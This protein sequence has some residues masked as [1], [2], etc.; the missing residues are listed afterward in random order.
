MA[1]TRKLM[2]VTAWLLS[3]DRDFLVDIYYQIKRDRSRYVVIKDFRGTEI[4]DPS[5]IREG[6]GKRRRRFAIIAN[7]PKN[8]DETP[9]YVYQSTRGI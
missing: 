1:R 5:Q 7:V 3:D 6:K 9:Q 2:R 8:Y 4:T